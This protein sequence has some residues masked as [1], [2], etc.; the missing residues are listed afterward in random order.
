LHPSANAI[1]THRAQI[2]AK[3]SSA[4]P[5]DIVK[6]TVQRLAVVDVGRTNE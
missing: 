6:S 1:E 3:L 2:I 5:D 4:D